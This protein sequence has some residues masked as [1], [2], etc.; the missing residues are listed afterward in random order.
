MG[1]IPGLGGFPGRGHGNPLQ[2]SCLENPMDRGAWWATVHRVTESDTTEQLHFYFTFTLWKHNGPQ[3][4]KTILRK[5]NRARGIIL[6]DFR[7]CFKVT[8]TKTVWYWHKIRYIDQRNRR[9]SPQINPWADGQLIHDK[10][11]KNIKWRKNSLFN[12]W[13][14]E[15]GIVS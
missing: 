2:Y 15:N 14:W 9:V 4:P 5:K 7:L 3:I 1:S 11:C 6:L 10:V 12:K 8:V 13:C